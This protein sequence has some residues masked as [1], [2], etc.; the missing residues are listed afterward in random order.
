MDTW[1]TRRKCVMQRNVIDWR[2]SRTLVLPCLLLKG[3]CVEHLARPPYCLTPTIAHTYT[4]IDTDCSL[5]SFSK[6]QHRVGP[7]FPLLQTRGCKSRGR[8]L[9]ARAGHDWL[10]SS[11]E[12]RQVLHAQCRSSGGFAHHAPRTRYANEEAP[13]ESGSRAIESTGPWK[14]RQRRYLKILAQRFS[15][16]PSARLATESFG[17][18]CDVSGVNISKRTLDLKIEFQSGNVFLPDCVSTTWTRRRLWKSSRLWNKARGYS[19]KTKAKQKPRKWE[20]REEKK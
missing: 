8:G 1:P 2:A 4:Q 3:H 11:F 13:Q 10:T 6:H 20:K 15:S 18:F 14:P 19:V 9:N 12:E 7:L 5:T 17:T 16:L